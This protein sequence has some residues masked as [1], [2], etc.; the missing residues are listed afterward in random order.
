MEDLSSS[1]ING[2]FLFLQNPLS[3]QRYIKKRIKDEYLNT[4]PLL[5]LQFKITC[6]YWI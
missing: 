4:Y 1:I 5:T 6:I 3:L 2:D